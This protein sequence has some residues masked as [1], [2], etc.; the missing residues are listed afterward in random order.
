MRPAA[1]PAGIDAIVISSEASQEPLFRAAS[2]SIATIP[3][4]RMY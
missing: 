4:F 1:L 2:I 3:I